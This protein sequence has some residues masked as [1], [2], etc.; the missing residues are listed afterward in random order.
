MISS[1]ISPSTLHNFL[2]YSLPLRWRDFDA[3]ASI[4]RRVFAGSHAFALFSLNLPASEEPPAWLAP[5]VT[6]PVIDAMG[7][8]ALAPA[9]CAVIA[10]GGECLFQTAPPYALCQHHLRAWYAPEHRLNHF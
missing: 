10:P 2:L 8:L 9:R 3:F 1:K 5:E 4:V 7:N 6:F